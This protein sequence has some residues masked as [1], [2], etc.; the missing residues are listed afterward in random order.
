MF[1]VDVP[2]FLIG[3]EGEMRR[4][5]GQVI[6]WMN[7]LSLVT[8]PKITVIDA[9]EYGQAFVNM[10]GGRQRGRVVAWPTADLS[11]MD[12]R[13]RDVVHNVREQDDPERYE[14]LKAEMTE[15]RRP[16]TWRR[17]AQCTP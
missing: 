10:G 4:H 8:V 7:A 11:F 3:V 9:Q 2:G 15:A 16:T 5:A 6:N 13:L 17:P 14:A 12:P 1:L